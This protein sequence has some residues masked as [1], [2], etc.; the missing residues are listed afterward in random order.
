MKTASGSWGPQ[1]LLR[2]SPD[3]QDTLLKM[4]VLAIAAV[5]C[6][7]PASPPP[8]PPLTFHILINWEAVSLSLTEKYDSLTDFQICLQA[9]LFL[10]ECKIELVL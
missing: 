10:I 8:L 6:K 5:L 9:H 2:M 7:L 1:W 4:M 3:K